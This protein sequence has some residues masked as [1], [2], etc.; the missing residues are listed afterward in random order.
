[1]Y[2]VG[3]RD[4]GAH[5]VIFA[6]VILC[7]TL[8]EVYLVSEEASSRPLPHPPQAP[9]PFSSNFDTVVCPRGFVVDKEEESFFV[10]IKTI[11]LVSVR[12]IAAIVLDAQ[13]TSSKLLSVT[14][15]YTYA[16]AI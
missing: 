5:L 4:N 8:N 9:A 1:M 16:R 7:Q 11:S 2:I 15:T 3:L 12:C 10:R 14:Y 13:N 6:V